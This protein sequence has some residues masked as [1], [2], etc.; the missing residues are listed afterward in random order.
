[1]EN[2]LKVILK[3]Y[4]ESLNDRSK[5]VAHVHE[6]YATQKALGNIIIS[7]FDMEIP[8]A[9][10]KEK[11]IDEVFIGRFV[12]M[13][14]E[15]YGTDTSQA[16]LAVEEWCNAYGN[17]YNSVEEEKLDFADAPIPECKIKEVASNENSND[18]GECISQEPEL[19]QKQLE[20]QINKEVERLEQIKSFQN[21]QSHLNIKT[22]ADV[23]TDNSRIIKKICMNY[24]P[25]TFDLSAFPNV[26]ELFIGSTYAGDL[27][28]ISGLEKI[29]R[30]SIHGYRLWSD[31][32]ELNLA[33]L[34]ELYVSIQKDGDYISLVCPK[35]KSLEICFDHPDAMRSKA[36]ELDYLFLGNIEKL[37][38]RNAEGINYREIACLQNLKELRIDDEELDNVEFLQEMYNLKKLTLHGKIV[39]VSPLR[40]LTNLEYL[41]LY[42][43][44]ITDA[45]CLENL[46]ELKYLDLFHNPVANDFDRSSIEFSRVTETDNAVADIKK[47]AERTV[48]H[49]VRF[50]WSLQNKNMDEMPIWQRRREE[51]DRKLPFVER[52]KE[53]QQFQFQ[54]GFN[55]VS[56]LGVGST[57]GLS[58]VQQH[59]IYLRHAL[60][61]YPYL[62]VTEDMKRLLEIESCRLMDRFCNPNSLVCILKGALIIIQTAISE[63][64]GEINIRGDIRPSDGRVLINKIQG[65]WYSIIDCPM[66]Q[67]KIEIDIRFV[68]K[69][70][71][72]DKDK[73][74]SSLAWSC[75]LPICM[76]LQ[77]NSVIG[78]GILI[79]EFKDDGIL[80]QNIAKQREIRL[81]EQ[82]GARY[83]IC[84]GS[85]KSYGD[86]EYAS[87]GLNYI[88]CKNIHDVIAAFTTNTE[89]DNLGVT[90]LDF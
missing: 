18:F 5:L 29:K 51:R 33:N 36:G 40:N 7:L 89:F 9:I 10:D 65:K 67:Y 58:A 60:K 42:E 1:M 24:S 90:F 73:Y 50:C 37:V 3:E 15:N 30:L 23:H 81:A 22:K 79:A 62:K 77:Q 78:K 69:E 54:I 76:C 45:A 85:K 12:R 39:D 66:E 38:L 11:Y 27:R 17:K 72:D 75:L 55:E 48:E 61:R 86:S 71:S 16:V 34:E 44:S 21:D 25:E 82:N 14:V 6:A 80:K 64:E 13:L 31:I 74:I 52:V 26:E 84:Y 70:L 49:A 4:P 46:V 2:H 19:I 68:Y 32:A 47:R 59:E 87:Y 35:L 83:V 20:E 57:P 63:G 41:N 43:N 28:N 88:G 56:P 53:N 8:N